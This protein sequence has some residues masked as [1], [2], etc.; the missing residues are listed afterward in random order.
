MTKRIFGS[1]IA[2]LVLMALGCSLC[3]GAWGQSSPSCQINFEYQGGYPDPPHYS[4]WPLPNGTVCGP[5]NGPFAQP[6][7]APGTGCVPPGAHKEVCMACSRGAAAG[8]PIDLGTGNTYISQSDIAI[9]GLGGGLRL[10]RTWN[11]M[12]PA[13]LSAYAGM[14]GPN[15]RSTYEERLIFNNCDGYLKWARGDGSVWSFGLVSMGP[16]LYRVVAPANDTTTIT[17]D[18]NNTNYTIISWTLVSKSGEKRIFDPTSGALVKVVDRN[19]NTTQLTYDASNRLT[20]V[21]DPASRHLNFAYTSSSSNL[22]STVSSDVGISLSYSYDSNGHLTQV[23]KPDNTTVS[24]TYDSN[25]RIA[26]V[27]DSNSKVLESHTYDALGRGL[28]SSRANGVDAV[29]V[30][31]P[32]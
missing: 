18:T 21:T 3:V 15:W 30:S 7:Q 16:N 17:T 28:T 29:T 5:S 19:G 4:P 23:T 10:E 2:R 9:P 14:F 27:T 25:S 11:S 1:M 32:Q 31:Y 22:V 24:F 8:S 13:V 6:C 26:T 12:Q 20:T